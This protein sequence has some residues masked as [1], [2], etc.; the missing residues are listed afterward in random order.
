[1]TRAIHFVVPDYT[2]SGEM[3]I[4]LEAIR[5][6]V[7]EDK[8]IE[9]FNT[10]GG[11]ESNGINALSHKN[12]RFG[13]ERIL[14]ERNSLAQTLQDTQGLVGTLGESVGG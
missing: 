2:L 11:D 8:A 14:D 12:V 10:L 9:T 7:P 3:F 5:D 1:M 6:F 4:T 13:L